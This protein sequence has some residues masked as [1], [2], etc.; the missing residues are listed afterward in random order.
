MARFLQ[1]EEMNEELVENI[2]KK[3]YLRRV[4]YLTLMSDQDL[5]KRFRFDRESI[6]VKYF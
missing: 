6:R 1:I 3:V 4:N 5:Y 2:P